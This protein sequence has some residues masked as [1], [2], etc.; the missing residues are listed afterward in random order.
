MKIFVGLKGPGLSELQHSRVKVQALTGS[1]ALS[2]K[3]TNP[4]YPGAAVIVRPGGGA[5]LIVE[6]ANGAHGQYSTFREALEIGCA[7][8]TLKVALY[9]GDK[10][11][12][13]GEYRGRI[14]LRPIQGK[15]LVL[16]ESDLETYVQGVLRSEVPASYHLEAMKAQAVLARTYALHPRI[17]HT[18]DGF[19]VC[20]S[21]TCCQAFNGVDPSLTTSQKTAI[22]ATRGKIL[23][24][25]GKPALALFSANAGGHTEDYSNCFS[26]LKTNKFPDA[27]IPY[28]KGIAEGK[29]PQGF[30]GEPAMRRLW[31]ESKPETVDSWSTTF[32]WQTHFTADA[33]EGHMHH[34]VETLRKDGQFGP[35]ITPPESQKFGHIQGFEVTRR[36]VSGVAMEL[37]IKTSTGTWTIAKELTIRSVFGNPDMKL[38][39]LRSGRI[40]F[41]QQRDKLGMIS[42]LTVFGLGFG[43]G[44]GLQQ[45]GAQGL[46]LQGMSYDKILS[47]YYPGTALVAL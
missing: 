37:A 5:E 2:N 27:P 14:E 39:R 31:S 43:H 17:D 36:G 4:T 13:E 10:Q 44:V 22:D 34:V 6:L 9:S 46:A 28:L 41:D 21:F 8:E 38:K 32:K 24:Y 30:P 35:F 7:G 11:I 18:S 42:G 47:R 23:T 25:E 40:F 1:L 26:N 15:L 16:L 20:D 29:L 3:Y 45:N 19:N 33:L 12:Y